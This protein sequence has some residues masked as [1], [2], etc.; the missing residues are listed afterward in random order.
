MEQKEQ[1]IEEHKLR[2]EVGEQQR[3]ELHR[4]VDAQFAQLQSARAQQFIRE[5]RS[6][7]SRHPNETA[8]RITNVLAVVLFLALMLCAGW[9]VLSTWD[10]F[11][12]RVK[13]AAPFLIPCCA[14]V[15]AFAI[16]TAKDLCL[17][18]HVMI[19]NSRPHNKIRA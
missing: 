6:R 8:L 7:K 11:C 14:I 5:Q 15:V 9:N 13:G 19:A 2:H 4:V 12:H 10:D 18:E 17:A 16:G 3:Q 1:E